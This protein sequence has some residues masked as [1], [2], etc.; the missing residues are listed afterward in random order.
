[1]GFH[2]QIA[3]NKFIG[4]GRSALVQLLEFQINDNIFIRFERVSFDQNYCMHLTPPEPQDR[5]ND[6]TVRLVGRRAIVMGNH[7]KATTLGWKS[8][9]FNNMPGPF[10][11][12]VTAGGAIRHP[13]FP[14]TQAN[15]NLIA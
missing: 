11:G 7:V 3:D 14:V 1:L 13:D 2:A 12:N 9:N 5:D 8:V 10:I 4:T 15:F 6:A